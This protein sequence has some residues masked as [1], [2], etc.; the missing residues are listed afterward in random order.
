MGFYDKNYP[1]SDVTETNI[2]FSI[3]NFVKIWDK[4]IDF[5]GKTEKKFVSYKSV[6]SLS[7]VC[8]GLNIKI[9]N[10]TIFPV[11]MY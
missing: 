2:S 8:W 3:H 1:F 9:T 5:P 11:F 6:I 10:P 7:K 4:I